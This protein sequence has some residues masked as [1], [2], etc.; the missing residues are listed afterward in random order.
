VLLLDITE[1]DDVLALDGL[2]VVGGVAAD[3]DH[4]QVELL[5]GR[6][7]TAGRRGAAGQRESSESTGSDSTDDADGTGDGGTGVGQEVTTRLVV[8]RSS[9]FR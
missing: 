4:A 9:R 1:G 7:A 5:P 2:Q 6:A 3:A 8:Q